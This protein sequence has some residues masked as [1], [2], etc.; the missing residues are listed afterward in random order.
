MSVVAFYL[1]KWNYI[2]QYI[3]VCY[4]KILNLYWSQLLLADA[5]FGRF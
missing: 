2:G 4:D 1:N 5:R 3:E